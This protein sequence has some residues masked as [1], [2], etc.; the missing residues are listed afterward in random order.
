[1]MELKDVIVISKPIEGIYGARI[2][3]QGSNEKV[4]EFSQVCQ[5]IKDDA[6]LMQNNYTT[7]EFFHQSNESIRA[8]AFKVAE[9]LQI[10]VLFM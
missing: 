3:F 4:V 7:Y 1:M 8:T 6:G 10:P 2:N 9:Q 5:S